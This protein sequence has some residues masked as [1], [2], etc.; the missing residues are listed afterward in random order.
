MVL[1][2][3]GFQRP[4]YDDPLTR[5][6]NRAKTLFGEDIDTSSQSI[7]GKYIRLNVEDAAECYELLEEIYYA[8]FPEVPEDR[9][10]TGAV[11]VCRYY[12]KSSYCS[13]FE[14]TGLR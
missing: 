10:W 7:L 3:K 2:D 12:Q 5:Q 6:E 14:S 11:C 9:A 13:K 4:T 1:T 8:I